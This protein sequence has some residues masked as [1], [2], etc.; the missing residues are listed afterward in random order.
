MTLMSWFK[1]VES[2]ACEPPKSPHSPFWPTPHTPETTMRR[3]GKQNGGFVSCSFVCL[4]PISGSMTA[5]W[6]FLYHIL[7]TN[8]TSCLSLG[9]LFTPALG[10][11]GECSACTRACKCRWLSPF[12]AY[13]FPFTSLA[14]FQWGSIQ[15]KA[16]QKPVRDGMIFVHLV[17]WH[18]P[19]R[20][21]FCSLTSQLASTDQAILLR[22]NYMY[23]S[24]SQMDLLKV[25]RGNRSQPRSHT[26]GVGFRAPDLQA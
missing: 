25:Q 21:I 5:L 16:T 2:W 6:L 12:L 17:Q 18:N 22:T 20:K 8:S 3:I 24:I 1:A 26:R 19:P 7:S 15:N 14:V 4:F 11:Q 13:S 9:N 23:S 10:L